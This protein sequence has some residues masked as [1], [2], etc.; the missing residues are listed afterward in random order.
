[1]VDSD[2]RRKQVFSKSLVEKKRRGRTFQDVINGL[3]FAHCREAGL[4]VEDESCGETSEEEPSLF[5]PSSE[6]ET[7]TNE[8]PASK[9]VLANGFAKPTATASNP[10]VPETTQSNP[11]AKPSGSL[12]S[13]SP[14]IFGQSA[15]LSTTSQSASSFGFGQSP[16]TGSS[17]VSAPQFQSPDTTS[18]SFIF[19]TNT[20]SSPFQKPP[21]SNTAIAD[22]LFKSSSTQ[23]LNA[24]FVPTT[25]TAPIN[26]T[27]FPSSNSIPSFSQNAFPTAKSSGSDNVNANEF[28]GSKTNQ[29]DQ[30]FPST[31]QSNSGVFGKPAPATPSAPSLFTFNAPPDLNT[32]TGS[33]FPSSASAQVAGH[34]Q[35]RE[36]AAFASGTESITKSNSLLSQSGN[37]QKSSN[38]HPT[39]PV[40]PGSTSTLFQ[41]KPNNASPMTSSTT[42]TPSTTT[43][44][45]FG[46]NDETSFS[47]NSLSKA[48]KLSSSKPLTTFGASQQPDVPFQPSINTSPQISTSSSIPTTSI[49][50][51]PLTSS[52]LQPQPPTPSSITKPISAKNPLG[53]VLRNLGSPLSTPT[54]SPITTSPGINSSSPSREAKERAEVRS[55]A[56]DDLSTEVVCGEYGLLEMII[57][58]V[59]APLVHKSLRKVAT[60]RERER[61]GKQFPGL[62]TSHAEIYGI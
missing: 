58:H 2:P 47:T 17:N 25:T 11:F 26:A 43:A 42:F 1:M 48:E 52:S 56:L 30:L 61:V 20:A 4:L 62:S 49:P 51:K 10:F 38:V 34:Q 21:I 16:S 19:G 45:R 32:I 39:A 41:F 13:T 6:D 40:Q 5:V 57:E 14:S 9:P 46:A 28:F 33:P 60:E 36:S 27:T 54:S 24:G 55:K 8:K 50:A 7:S 15:R 35:D 23:A 59:A 3:S 29:I 53:H 37:V 12:N 22:K 44:A 31:S 18:P